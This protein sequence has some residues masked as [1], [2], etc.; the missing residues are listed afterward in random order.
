MVSLF[1]IHLVIRIELIGTITSAKV[2]ADMVISEIT[3]RKWSMPE[4][5]PERYLTWNRVIDAQVPADG[6]QE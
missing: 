2:V 1:L 5:L 3:G 6:L 4:W